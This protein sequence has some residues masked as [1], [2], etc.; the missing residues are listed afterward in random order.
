ML[1]LRELQNGFRETLLGAPDAR[2]ASAI[3]EDGLRAEA[4]LDIYRHHVFT[5]LTAALRSTYPVVCRLVDE[6][7]FAYAADRFIREEPPVGPCLFEYGARFPDFLADFPA[8]R[9]LAYL[10]DVARLEWALHAAYHADDA[11]TLAPLGLTE[12]DPE[13]TGDLTFRFDPAYGLL[14]SRWPIDRIWHA[15]RMDGEPA[16]VDLGTGEAWLE[17]S[18]HDDDVSF[19]SLT[20]ATYAFR[21]PLVDGGSLAEAVASALAVDQRFDLVQALGALLRDGILTGF[22]LA[23]SSDE[24]SRRE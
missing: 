21:R 4:R 23:A 22:T 24:P 13:R 10:P 7:F 9:H 19:R 12:I 8:C 20:A 5:T 1:S 15:N 3:A 18:R 2:L 14:A 6:R 17:V 16:Q 11:G